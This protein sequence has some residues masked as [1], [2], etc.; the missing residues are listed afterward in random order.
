MSPQAERTPVP[1]QQSTYQSIFNSIAKRGNPFKGWVGL[2][3]PG[4]SHQAVSNPGGGTE[5]VWL[6]AQQVRVQEHWQS[7]AH[8][9]WR[10][11]CSPAPLHQLAVS[12]SA[13]KMLRKK[14]SQSPQ[15]AIDFCPFYLAT[16]YNTVARW[17]VFCKTLFSI[18]SAGGSKLF[19]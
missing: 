8:L 19:L 11:T 18:S 16:L 10:S 7:C 13:A 6:A 15:A 5:S 12:A 17:S 1:G 2:S 9:S 4:A 14:I 3:K